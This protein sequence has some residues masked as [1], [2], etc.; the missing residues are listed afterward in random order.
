MNL[1]ENHSLT[2]IIN[3]VAPVKHLVVTWF[4]ND[5]FIHNQTFNSTKIG[6]NNI[7]SEIHLIPS[8]EDSTAVYRCE[9]HLDLDLPE[10]HLPNASKEYHIAVHCK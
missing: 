8:R 3:N 10:G 1:L 9:A 4:K 7:T 6:P 2:C 5:M